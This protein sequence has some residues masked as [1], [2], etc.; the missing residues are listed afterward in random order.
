MNRDRNPVTA[1]YSGVAKALHWSIAGLVVLQVILAK[2]AE[3]SASELQELAL[4]VNHRSVGITVLALAIVRLAW[5]LYR[6][7]PAPLPMPAWQKTT[8]QVAHWGL[9]ALL[10]LVPLSG[11]LMSSA[12]AVQIEWFRLFPI[13][14]LVGADNALKESFEEIHETLAKV[15]VVIALLH[16][17]AGLKHGLV[18]RNGALGRISS[19]VSISV[20]VSIVVLGFLFLA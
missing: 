4:L 6:P 15:L 19:T 12:D 2:L 13:P 18:D 1:D 3:E 8:S 10:F 16:V 11:W 14:N 5:R 17:A 7:A 9:Y 20:F